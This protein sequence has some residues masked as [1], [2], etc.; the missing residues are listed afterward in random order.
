MK[1][2]VNDLAY[3]SYVDALNKTIDQIEENSHTND[4]NIAKMRL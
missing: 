4:E 3:M 1:Y 2:T